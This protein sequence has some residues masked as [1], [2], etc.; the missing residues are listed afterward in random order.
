MKEGAWING[1]TFEHFFVSEHA[2]WV[3]E[4]ANALKL[5]IPT[6]VWEKIKNM[7]NDFNGPRRE[8]ILF[9]VMQSGPFIRMRGQGNL[10][11]FE[12]MCKSLDAVWGVFTFCQKYAGDYTGIRLNNLRTKESIDVTYREF[13]HLMEEGEEKILRVAK[14]ITDKQLSV[15]A[16][17]FLESLAAA[18]EGK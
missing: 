12:F 5:G 9:T 4:E 2:S 10:Y 8:A 11:A 18:E 3:K 1:K 13:Q 14:A 16:S 17:E 15:F 6:E 7:P